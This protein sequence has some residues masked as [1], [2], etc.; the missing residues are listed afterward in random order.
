MRSSSG[1]VGLEG[2]ARVEDARAPALGEAVGD[3]RDALVLGDEPAAHRLDAVVAGEAQPFQ[4]AHADG[5]AGDVLQDVCEEAEVRELLAQRLQLVL[6]HFPALLR[7]GGREGV[8]YVVDD[9][10]HAAVCAL[11]QAGAAQL[12]VALVPQPVDV[13][14]GLVRRGEEVA[15][16]LGLAG[17]EALPQRAYLGLHVGGGRRGHTALPLKPSP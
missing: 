17:P 5:L 2:C 1:S 8:A 9:P 11:Q 14:R 13:V 7:L 10:L 16:D 6:E 15:C 4:R 3:V 12:A